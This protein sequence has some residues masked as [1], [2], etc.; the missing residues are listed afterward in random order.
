MKFDSLFTLVRDYWQDRASRKK[1]VIVQ[2]AGS[3]PGLYGKYPGH[4][5]E[6]KA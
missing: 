2:E 5:E 3:V 1:M 6:D 4:K